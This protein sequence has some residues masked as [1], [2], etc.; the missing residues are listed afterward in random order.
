MP[1]LLRP[2]SL[3]PNSVGWVAALADSSH[4]SS[5]EARLAP[6]TPGQAAAPVFSLGASPVWETPEYADSLCGLDFWPPDDLAA[7]LFDGFFERIHPVRWE[8]KAFVRTGVDAS[9]RP[10]QVLPF[11]REGPFRV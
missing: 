1:N 4:S 8:L 3:A 6:T 10:H 2:V 5:T 11:L 9:V 7:A